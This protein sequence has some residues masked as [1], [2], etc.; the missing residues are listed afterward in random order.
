LADTRFVGEPDLYV[1]GVEI[2]RAGDFCQRD[3]KAVLK[4]SI[5]PSAWA[6]WRGRVDSLR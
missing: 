3:G 4:S 5:A 6:W 2:L 1:A